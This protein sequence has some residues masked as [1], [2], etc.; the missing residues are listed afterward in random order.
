M[1]DGIQNKSFYICTYI[2]L[3]I[4]CNE[5]KRVR[6]PQATS[7][8]HMGTKELVNARLYSHKTTMAQ[9]NLFLIWQAA[10][11]RHSVANTS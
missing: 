7:Y 8:E 3:Y 5:K 10:M 1:T 6:T 4:D 9:L 2:H 11:R